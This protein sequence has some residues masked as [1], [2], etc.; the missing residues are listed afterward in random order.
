MLIIIAN[1]AYV[2]LRDM[3]F[4]FRVSI[5]IPC[6]VEHESFVTTVSLAL[7]LFMLWLEMRDPHR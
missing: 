5:R 4:V 1:I 2:F 6:S 3:R 7:T